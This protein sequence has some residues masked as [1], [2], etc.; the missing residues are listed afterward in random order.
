MGAVLIGLLV[1]LVPTTLAAIPF[2]ILGMAIGVAEVCARHY[3]KY[4]SWKWFL[5]P[6]GVSM[7][8]AYIYA[9][10]FSVPFGECACVALFGGGY[11]PLRIF[12]LLRKKLLPVMD[13]C[14]VASI[15]YISI[16]YPLVLWELTSMKRVL[17]YGALLGIL[18]YFMRGFS[19]EKYLHNSKYIT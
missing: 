10:I 4:A 1:A 12:E 9:V 17:F 11:A 19:G 14:I 15:T 5:M 2:S 8:M 13:S 7:G 16:C 18:N 6:L 3:G